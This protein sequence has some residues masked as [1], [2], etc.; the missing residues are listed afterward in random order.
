VY[1][2]LKAQDLITSPTFIVM[3]AADTF[4]QPT[5][6][7]NQLWQTD[8]T[9]LKVIGWGWFYLSTVLDDYSRFILAWR[10]CTG[11]AASDVSD[12]LE[13]ALAFA[14]IEKVKVKHRP[15]LRERRRHIEPI[16]LRWGVPRET[17]LDQRT[18]SIYLDEI[19]H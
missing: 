6:R 19:A 8:F 9:Y 14:D 17:A 4:S 3:Q 10:L 11:M 16:D 13:E 12:T 5:K 18:M 15:R 1:R 7:V 2:L